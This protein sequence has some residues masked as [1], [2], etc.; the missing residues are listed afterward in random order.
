MRFAP[1]VGY[2]H[3]GTGDVATDVNL[4]DAP[5]FDPK[6]LAIGAG[7]TLTIDLDN[8]GAYNHTFTLSSV[9]NATIN[10]SLSPTGLDGYFTNHTPQAGANVSLAPGGMATVVLTYTTADIGDSFEFVS[11]V[12]YQF[13]AGHAGITERHIERAPARPPGEHHRDLAPVPAERTGRDADVPTPP[14]STSR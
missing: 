10:T 13:Q 11:L 3:P 2:A 9:P 6:Y 4:T 14:R 8:V 12:P 7:A 5:S 1:S